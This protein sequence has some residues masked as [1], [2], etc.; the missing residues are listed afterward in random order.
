MA[1][2]HS[3]TGN[4]SLRLSKAI[5]L[6]TSD[7]YSFLYFW[8]L[9][10]HGRVHSAGQ[11][12]SNGACRHCR[13]LCVLTLYLIKLVAPSATSLAE[14]SPVGLRWDS[15]QRCDAFVL[16]LQWCILPGQILGRTVQELLHP[17]AM[18]TIT[19]GLPPYFSHFLFSFLPFS[20]SIIL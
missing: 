7:L 17:H 9:K 14:Q 13:H 15:G 5:E 16:F 19:N 20:L 1:A 3:W 18:H 6:S 12:L 8:I 10:K 11:L 2:S 4:M